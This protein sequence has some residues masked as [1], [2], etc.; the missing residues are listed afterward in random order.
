MVLSLWA[1]VSIMAAPASAGVPE[2]AAK[3]LDGDFAGAVSEW[4]VP[5]AAGDPDAEFNL[6]QA[7]KLGRGVPTDMNRAIDLY[8]R[9]AGKGHQRA[10]ANIGLLLLQQGRTKAAMPHIQRAA[11]AGDPKNQ[12][13]LGIALFNGD[14]LPKD[15]VQAY[16]WMQRSSAAG[17]PQAATALAEIGKYLN[18]SERKGDLALAGS[19][20]REAGMPAKASTPG[21]EPI[22]PEKSARQWRVQLGAY[23]KAEAA[24]VSWKHLS[25]RL[26]ILSGLQPLYVDKKEFVRLQA[27]PIASRAAAAR[28]CAALIANGQDCFPVSS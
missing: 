5:A 1:V 6:G 8:T 24:K 20:V 19:P 23:S 3:W 13:A 2:G 16:A 9:A 11:A 18:E 7:Y 17:L 15:H 14:G 10:I 26:P 27:G 25:N 4:R 12:Y 22:H 21:A 28:I